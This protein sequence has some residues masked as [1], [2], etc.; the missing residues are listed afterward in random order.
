[1]IASGISIV[2]ILIGTEMG[3]F[4]RILGTQHLTG[5]QWLICIGVALPVVVVTEIRK[6]LL[7]RQS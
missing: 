1:L 5:Q 3:F 7:R 2:A 4:N 6:L